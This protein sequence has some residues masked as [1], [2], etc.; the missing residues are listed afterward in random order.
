M[1]TV[2]FFYLAHEN[3]PF[4]P[5]AYS[6]DIGVI[7]WGCLHCR[8]VYLNHSVTRNKQQTATRYK[9]DMNEN[10]PLRQIIGA[11]QRRILYEK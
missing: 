8:P 10:A 7:V 2:R 3:R 1:H 6:A 4:Q 11:G 5:F 9:I